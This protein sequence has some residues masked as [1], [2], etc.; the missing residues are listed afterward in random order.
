VFVV[1]S[2]AAPATVKVTVGAQKLQARHTLM[3]RK[4]MITLDD[5]AIIKTGETLEVAIAN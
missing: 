1:L 5:P 4:L 2:E 3:N